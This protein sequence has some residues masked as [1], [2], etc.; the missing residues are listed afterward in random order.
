MTLDFKRIDAYHAVS[1]PYTI[2]RCHNARGGSYVAST[3][4]DRLTVERYTG[5]D[6]EKAAYARAKA[7]CEAHST[8]E[9]Q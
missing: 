6:D 5:A 2:A 4:G 8:G 1:G 9:N 3:K 7:A